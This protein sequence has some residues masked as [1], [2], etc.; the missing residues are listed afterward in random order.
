MA[1][2]QV[3]APPA[4]LSVTLGRRLASQ[5]LFLRP[6]DGDRGSYV[7]VASEEGTR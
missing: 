6:R 3:L 7:P 5:H 2:L 1:W 4:V